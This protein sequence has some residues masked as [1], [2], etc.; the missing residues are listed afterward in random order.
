[1]KIVCPVFERHQPVIHFSTSVGY[2]YV[3]PE[4]ELLLAIFPS[5]MGG[6]VLEARSA[7]GIRLMMCCG[8]FGPSGSVILARCRLPAFKTLSSDL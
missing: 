1:V 3:V 5:V 8:V 2:T 7:M 6:F 4:P